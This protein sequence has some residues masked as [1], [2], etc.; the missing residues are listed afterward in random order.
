M[1]NSIEEALRLTPKG[2]YEAVVDILKAGLV[3]N[4]QSSPGMGKSDIIRSIAKAFKLKLIDFRLS[5][6]DPTDLAG[7]PT[8][9]DNRTA[10]MPPADFPLKGDPIPDGYNGWLLFLDEINSA[11]LAVQAASYKLILDKAVGQ[12]PLHESVAIVA[13]GNLATDKAIV[14]RMGT[15]MQSRMIHL[16]MKADRDSWLEWALDNGIDYRIRAFIK[17]KDTLLHKFDPNHSDKT[18]PCP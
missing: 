3:P 10:Y 16:E 4:L 8:I 17:F 14:N 13:A 1:D 11:P 7:I 6:A 15:A 18:F 2:V 5:Q 12:H 9:K